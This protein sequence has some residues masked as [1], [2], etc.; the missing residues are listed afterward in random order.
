MHVKNEGGGGGIGIGGSRN[1]NMN[2]NCSISAEEQ[3][4]ILYSADE[5]KPWICKNCNRN[6]KWKNSLKCHLKNECG[7]PPKFYCIRNCG[8][9]T[10]INS[11]L[12]RHLNSKFCKPHSFFEAEPK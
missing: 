6:Y 10:N 2:Y 8:Y 1:V 11:N 9:K 5:E 7:K 4:D 12:K 3:K